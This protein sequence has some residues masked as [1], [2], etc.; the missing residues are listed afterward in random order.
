MESL[1]RSSRWS[2]LSYLACH[3]CALLLIV[4]YLTL[5]QRPANVRL[6]LPDGTERDLHTDYS[7]GEKVLLIRD[8]DV[9]VMDAWTI[10]ITRS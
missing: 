4:V 3:R 8:P 9:R 10:T 2:V 1:S 5:P 6:A 7:N